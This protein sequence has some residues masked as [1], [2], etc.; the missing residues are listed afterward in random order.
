MHDCDRTMIRS[1]TVEFCVDGV[2][3]QSPATAADMQSKG[4]PLQIVFANT[5]LQE[6]SAIRAFGIIRILR[7]W[8][9]SRQS[10]VALCATG[11][12]F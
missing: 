5:G 10:G 9:G 8:T 1:I 3:L 12:V 6:A 11:R 4:K 2:L 7:C